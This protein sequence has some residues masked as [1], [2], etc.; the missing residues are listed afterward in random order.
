[1]KAAVSEVENAAARPAAGAG[2]RL[3]LQEALATLRLA[4]QQH[5]EAVESPTG[6][7]AQ[8]VTEAPRL[9]PSTDRLR[10]EHGEINASIDRMIALASQTAEP[11]ELRNDALDTLVAIARHRQR[12]ADLVYEAYEVDIGGQ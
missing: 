7:L 11:G 12:G 4:F 1:M 10:V 3:E 6:L 5:V 9:S 2:W 8:L